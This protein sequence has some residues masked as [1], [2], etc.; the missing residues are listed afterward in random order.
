MS[1][2]MGEGEHGI[3]IDWQYIHRYRIWQ[4]PSQTRLLQ[5]TRQFSG[6]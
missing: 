4:E 2:M 6:Y 1:M 3:H 5:I